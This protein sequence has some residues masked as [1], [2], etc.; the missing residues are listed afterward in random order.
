VITNQN[1]ILQYCAEIG[2]H[3]AYPKD[4][5]KRGIVNTWMLWES[6]AWFPACYTYLV[7]Y[8]VKPLLNTLPSEE[9][10]NS[11]APRFHQLAKNL[12][13]QLA[14]G[15]WVCGDEVTIADFAIAAPMHLYASQKLPLEDYPNILRW[16]KEGMEKIPAWQNTQ[17]A[18][19]KALLPN[20]S[21]NGTSAT[22]GNSQSDE[23]HTEVN[24]SKQLEDKL[25]ELYF[26]ETDD[27]KD[28][29][30]PGDDRRPIV[31]RD[32]WHKAKEL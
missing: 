5:R 29:H 7:E 8:V 15:K 20:Q 24:Y 21:S 17:G 2:D 23:V 26:Y 9:V 18:V 28:V 16:M 10:I 31:I 25:T 4:V 13:G 27:A 19:N 6:S 30:E 11:A 12:D 22:N 32:G 3:S 14:K 1:A